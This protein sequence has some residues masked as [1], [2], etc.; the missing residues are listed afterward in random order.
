[1]DEAATMKQTAENEGKKRR[2]S[3]SQLQ[4][5]MWQ[6]LVE[7]N[8]ER[9][10]QLTTLQERIDYLETSKLATIEECN[11]QLN[12]LRAGVRVMNQTSSKYG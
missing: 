5:A 8:E 12:V 4:D 6:Q 7:V 9:K 11:R 2:E 1:M 3:I 10:K